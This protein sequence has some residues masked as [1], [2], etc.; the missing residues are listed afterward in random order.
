M[1]ASVAVAIT[2]WAVWTFQTKRDAKITEDRTESDIKSVETRLESEIRDIHN[3]LN[4][5]RV[6]IRDDIKVLWADFNRSKNEQSAM[7]KDVAYIR[8]I[9]EPRAQNKP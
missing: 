7:A 6:E 4:K 3:H 1:V 9:L 8:G 2:L 5:A